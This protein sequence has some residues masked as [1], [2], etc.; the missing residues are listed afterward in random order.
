MQ[1]LFELPQRLPFAGMRDAVRSWLAL[2]QNFNQIA[3]ARLA[4]LNQIEQAQPL[5]VGKG[6]KQEHQIG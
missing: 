1:A 2:P 6:R 4:A 5:T 3:D